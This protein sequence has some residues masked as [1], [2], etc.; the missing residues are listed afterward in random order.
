MVGRDPIHPGPGQPGAPEN[1]A[2]ANHHGNLH[3]H[4]DDVL[5]LAGDPPE[6]G[7]VDAVVAGAHQGFTGELHEDSREARFVSHCLFLLAD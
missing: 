2:A 6:E 3:T 4:F 1:V 7:G 5:Q